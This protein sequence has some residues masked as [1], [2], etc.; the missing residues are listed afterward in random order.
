MMNFEIA[1]LN[2]VGFDKGG[3]GIYIFIYGVSRKGDK[4]LF[5]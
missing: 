4:Q 1:W 5:A 3:T 2:L